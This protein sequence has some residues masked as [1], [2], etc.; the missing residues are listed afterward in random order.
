MRKVNQQK[1]EGMH[2]VL[3]DGKDQTG[4]NLPSGTYFY[5][6]EVLSPTG[7]RKFIERKKMILMR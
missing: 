4:E 7:E 6:L 1:Q 2:P 5:Q 3:W